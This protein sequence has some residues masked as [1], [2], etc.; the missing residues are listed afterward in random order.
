MLT[1]CSAS[2]L[3]QNLGPSPIPY[4]S[5]FSILQFAPRMP[6]ATAHCYQNSWKISC[7]SSFYESLTLHPVAWRACA[8]SN[9][10]EAVVIYK[11]RCGF[12][13]AW[14]P[15]QLF[16]PSSHISASFCLSTYRLAPSPGLSCW[17]RIW[18]GCCCCDC[19]LP[20]WCCPPPQSQ[21]HRCEIGPHTQY[22]PDLSLL[23]SSDSLGSGVVAENA[24]DRA[25]LWSVS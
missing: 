10:A 13:W 18:C 5:W 9:F 22:H 25:S 23:D 14:E 3:S 2:W 11:I 19:S 4:L 6:S 12:A 24:S 15:A 17:F 16:G 1:A 21:T 20:R 8:W 7:S